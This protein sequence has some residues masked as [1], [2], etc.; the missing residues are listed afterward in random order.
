MSTLQRLNG[1]SHTQ[2]QGRVWRKGAPQDSAVQIHESEQEAGLVEHAR[3][4][5]AY[6]INHSSLLN[7][8]GR[9]RSSHREKTLVRL[10]LL[11][12]PM[13]ISQNGPHNHGSGSILP[14]LSRLTRTSRCARSHA[15]LGFEPRGNGFTLGS[16]TSLISPCGFSC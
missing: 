10:I 15:D 2:I 9:P 13:P 6:D 16:E 4:F 1:L 8:A 12:Y 5:I 14:S 3:T 7:V 11:R